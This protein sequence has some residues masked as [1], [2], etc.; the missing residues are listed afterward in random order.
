[1]QTSI[2]DLN[3]HRK[4]DLAFIDGSLGLADHHLGGPACDPPVKTLVAGFDPV[5][6]DA[7]GSELL[8][9]PWQQVGHIKMAD[10]VLGCAE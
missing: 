7:Y 1:M 2:F 3:R 10:G 4:P 9:I 5:K 8:G 6:V